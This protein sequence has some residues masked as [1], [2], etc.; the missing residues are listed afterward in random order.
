MPTPLTHTP[1]GNPDGSRSDIHEVVDNFI[2]SEDLP[3]TGGL[4]IRADDLSRRVI[5]GA[6]GSGKNVYLRRLRATASQNESVYADVVQQ[7]RQVLPVLRQA[8]PDRK[9]D[10]ALVLRHHALASHTHATYE[11]ALALPLNR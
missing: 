6:K 3:V 9:V 2:V 7:H 11:T 5:V 8:E 1:F 10:A 4:G